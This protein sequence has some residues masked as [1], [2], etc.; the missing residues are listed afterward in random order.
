MRFVK[1][2]RERVRELC[3][4]RRRCIWLERDIPRPFATRR[5]DTLTICSRLYVSGS[6][7]ILLNG[8]I[9]ISDIDLC[10]C[11]S[12]T[13]RIT[14]FS[15]PV[16]SRSSRTSMWTC[17]S[18]HL[19]CSWFLFCFRST[20]IF[21]LNLYDFLYG[22][23]TSFIGIR[24]AGWTRTIR[25]WTRCSSI[26][27][28]MQWARRTRT[29]RFFQDLGSIG[30]NRIRE[31]MFLR[32]WREEGKQTRSVRGVRDRNQK[33]LTYLTLLE[34]RNEKIVKPDYSVLLQPTLVLINCLSLIH[35]KWSK[36]GA[37]KGHCDFLS[38]FRPFKKYRGH[39]RSTV[40]AYPKLSNLIIQ[41]L[42]VWLS[43]IYVRISTE[44]CTLSRMCERGLR[45]FAPRYVFW[46]NRS[47]PSARLTAFD[48][49]S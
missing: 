42:W 16:H 47:C 12:F 44:L 17:S 23:G 37:W 26:T 25:S 1:W 3:F 10:S 31:G 45:E 49:Q 4:R 43:L 39:C 41:R 2:S 15:I 27:V 8:S 48:L 9:T 36:E 35:R 22:Y 32:T 6:V 30:W 18:D 46:C 19:R 14:C 40:G 7:V 38:S 13:E 34:D 24:R 29:T 28:I 20:W 33:I 21:S 5:E 11:G